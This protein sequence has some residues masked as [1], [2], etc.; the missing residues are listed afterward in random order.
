MQEIIVL[1]RA[2]AEKHIFTRSEAVIS[3][4]GTHAPEDHTPANI[5]CNDT[6]F[7]RLQFDDIT[8]TSECD[9]CILMTEAQAKQIIQFVKEQQNAT[10]FYVHCFAG[11][12]R[13]A[14]VAAGLA[15]IGLV[16]WPDYDKEVWGADG[17]I[18]RYV[19]N[20]HVKTLLMRE[21]WK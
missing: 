11:I 21:G 15:G 16:A 5:V 6:R 20:P 14:G 3:I 19:P 9:G 13:S 2:D 8:E 17:W 7:L 12:S 4:F 1:S 18:K 10:K